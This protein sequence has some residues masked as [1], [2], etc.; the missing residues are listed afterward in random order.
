[1]CRTKGWPRQARGEGDVERGERGKEE[2]KDCSTVM[3]ML[4]LLVRPF[5]DSMLACLFLL[6]L[7]ERGTK[8]AG[9]A[10]REAHHI[11]WCPFLCLLPHRIAPLLDFQIGN[12]AR[13]RGNLGV[14]PVV[15]FGRSQS[16]KEEKRECMRINL[17]FAFDLYGT[18][19]PSL[20]LCSMLGPKK[21]KLFVFSFS[22]LFFP[23]FEA[24]M[25]L[26]AVTTSYLFIAHFMNKG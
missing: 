12:L 2:K 26:C 6:L 17:F 7:I 14:W 15:P 18:F 16:Q 5:Y 24:N 8:E 21:N 11:P 10:E 1:M 19:K 20:L 3:A 22:F 9:K 4:L 13:A 25:G 23:R